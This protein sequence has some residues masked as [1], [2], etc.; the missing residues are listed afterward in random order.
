MRPVRLLSAS[1][2]C[3]ASLAH[4]ADLHVLAAGAF[5][6]VV[7]AVQPVFQRA[8]GNHLRVEVDT[9]GGLRDRVAKGEAFDVVVSTPASMQGMAG[10]LAEASVQPLAR[11]GIGVAVRRGAPLPDVSSVDAFRRTLLQARSVSYVDPAS[12]G[13]S[14][15]Y[16][17]RLFQ[18]WGVAPQIR[19]KAILVHGGHAA[20]QVADGRAELAMQQISELVSV[21]GVVLVG[22]LPAQIQKYTIYAGAISAQSSDPDAA[23]DLL[24]ALRG[25]VARGMLRTLGMDSP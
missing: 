6:Q 1:L 3:A 10:R 7:E 13:T 16:L 12:G 25:P 5:A 15:V 14:G 8:T 21:P 11:V 18:D 4:A 20:Q 2:A 23:R 22:P 9:A 19:A 24:T 17:D